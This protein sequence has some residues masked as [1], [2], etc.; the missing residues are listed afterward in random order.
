M[1]E[2]MNWE[3][4]GKIRAALGVSQPAMADFFGLTTREYQ[5]FEWGEREIPHFYVFALERIAM[6]HAV[7]NGDPKVA[8]SAVREDALILAR[9]SGN[10]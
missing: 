8:P 2:T 1:P 10:A 7:R 3:E 6:I 4:L 9:L 5:A